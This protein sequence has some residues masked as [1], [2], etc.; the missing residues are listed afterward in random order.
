MLTQ[1]ETRKKTNVTSV[2]RMDTTRVTNDI[3]HQVSIDVTT[4]RPR[5]SLAIIVENRTT[6]LGIA[7]QENLIIKIKKKNSKNKKNKLKKIKKN[8]KNIRKMI[9]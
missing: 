6:T 9:I 3:T 2:N 7:E 8:K 5:N 4:S 1:T